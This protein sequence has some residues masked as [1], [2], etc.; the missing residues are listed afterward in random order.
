MHYSIFCKIRAGNYEKLKSYMC[1]NHLFD[2]KRNIMSCRCLS[3][4]V[5]R[6]HQ[7]FEKVKRHF[8]AIRSQ[9]SM[10]FK[11]KRWDFWI[12]ELLPPLTKSFDR[13]NKKNNRRF[14]TF[15]ISSYQLWVLLLNIHVINFLWNWRKCEKSMILGHSK[16]IVKTCVFVSTYPY[17]ISLYCFIH[18]ASHLTKLQEMQIQDTLTIEQEQLKWC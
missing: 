13:H 3:Y 18:F 7:S 12:I 9:K 16:I 14:I 10:K 15:L 17:R 1:K 8:L 6:F 2:P 4:H 5:A 11:K